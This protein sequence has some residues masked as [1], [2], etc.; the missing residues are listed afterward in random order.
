MDS[1]TLKVYNDREYGRMYSVF[2]IG[3]FSLKLLEN[4]S[5]V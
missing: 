1:H 2:K 5:A 4:V 3:M